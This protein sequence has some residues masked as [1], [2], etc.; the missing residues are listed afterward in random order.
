MG[1]RGEGCRNARVEAMNKTDA[2]LPQPRLPDGFSAAGL[3][4]GV[5]PSGAKDLALIAADASCAAAGTFTTNQLAAAPVKVCREHL[6]DGEARAIVTCSGIANAATGDQGLRSARQM[7]ETTAQAI[8]CRPEEVLVC[9]TGCIGVQL[10]MD[11]IGPGIPQAASRL[12][13]EGWPDAAEAIMTTD[14]VP[15][16]ASATADLDGRALRLAGMAKGAGMICPNMA[17]MLCFIVTDA[18]VEQRAL[19]EALRRAVGQSFNRITV[20]GDMS[21]NDTVLFLANG[22]A[23]GE[24]MTS[25]SGAFAPFQGALTELCTDLAKQIVRDGEGSTKTMAVEVRGARSEADAHRVAKAVANSPLVKTA[26]YGRDFNW[27][28]VAA[29]VGSAGVAFDPRRVTIAIGNIV[30]YDRGEA[31]AHP[32][33]LAATAFAEGEV[34]IEVDL[35]DGT[36]EV[37]VWGC[38]LSEDYVRINAEYTT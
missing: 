3:H 23:G 13:P 22:A 31:V 36:A 28:R 16:T 10:P 2:G 8:G 7:A 25:A 4:C 18:A 29:A 1:G 24:P 5:K 34:L 38:D 19:Q 12:A 33:E 15:K 6:Q 21:T 14:T 26:V 35:G 11:Q 37:T 27:G 20:D 17:T 30:G 9:S 32:G